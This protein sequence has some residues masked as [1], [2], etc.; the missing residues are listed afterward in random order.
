MRFGRDRRYL[1]KLQSASSP[2]CLASI[3]FDYGDD[4]PLNAALRVRRALRRGRVG[5]GHDLARVL[6]GTPQLAAA[7]LRVA[8]GRSPAPR[9]DA[10]RILAVLEQLPRRES[11]LSLAEATDPRGMPR[12]R[13]DWR[14]GDEEGAALDDFVTVL[15]EELRR[16][17]A[18]TLE[19]E[20]WVG[21]PDWQEHVFDAF[22]PAGT[23]R[24]GSV[25]DAD[26]RLDGGVYVCGGSVFP[27]S[28]C[29]NPTLTILALA[30]RLA[31]HLRQA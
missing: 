25:V 10:V 29:A 20:S 27:T 4:A 31:G 11:T 23:T 13:V 21:T 14:L 16:T 15:D 1:P 7:G 18:G 24:M 22:H 3:V 5:S 9:P 28:G 12:L 2:A 19:R 26:C 17:G 30:L 6:L 8:R